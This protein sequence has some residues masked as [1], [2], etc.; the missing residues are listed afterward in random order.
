LA[1]TWQRPGLWLTAEMRRQLLGHEHVG[2]RCDLERSGD[3]VV[4]GDVTKSIP[5]RLASE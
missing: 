4:V 1:R 2:A 3:R 5:R